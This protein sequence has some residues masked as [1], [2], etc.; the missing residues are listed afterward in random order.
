MN[1]D[2]EICERK[3][4]WNSLLS[5]TENA[6]NIVIINY[7]EGLEPRSFI[8]DGHYEQGSDWIIKKYNI[9]MNNISRIH[10]DTIP[11]LDMT[12]G[13]EIFA[14]AF[15]CKVVYPGNN[16]PFAIYKIDSI[17]EISTLKTPNLWDTR[18]AD[19]FE[20]AYQLR[21]RTDKNAVFKLPDIQSPLD[22]AALIM[23]KEKFYMG[24]VDEP[25]AIQELTFKTFTLLTQFLDEWFKEFGKEFIAHHPDY[26][27]EYGITLSED[28]IGSFGSEIFLKLVLDELNTLSNRYGRIGVHCCA[29]S[30]HQWANIKKIKNLCLLNLNQP[31][32]IIKEAYGFFKDTCCQM[33]SFYSEGNID[34]WQDR[35]NNGERIIFQLYAN[36]LE[37]AVNKL[38]ALRGVGRG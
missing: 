19:I 22:I 15:G 11:F 27:M 14:E 23:N 4:S 31:P 29:N 21:N 33:H 9:M 5:G 37:D 34:T 6:E 7:T 10:D 2:H 25:A 20:M 18:L 16:N 12:T 38:E 17:S 13:T 35:F 26:Y 32:E 1:I 28:E 24:M 8:T 30:K 36:S 3:K